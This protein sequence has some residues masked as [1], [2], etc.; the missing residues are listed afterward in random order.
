MTHVRSN[1]TSADASVRSSYS[2]RFPTTIVHGDPSSHAKLIRNPITKGWG[3]PVIFLLAIVLPHWT[4]RVWLST[5]VSMATT[6]PNLGLVSCDEHWSYHQ[7]TALKSTT[8]SLHPKFI[9]AN[10][11][12]NRID[13]QLA[14]YC[15]TNSIHGIFMW[16]TFNLR[17]F[18]RSSRLRRYTKT[19]R[20]HPWL[21]TTQWTACWTHNL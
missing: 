10:T 8:S 3:I 13:R 14:I 21:W 2:L 6:T 12:Q 19:G 7:L 20:S 9:A 11:F 17:T 16:P 18:S 15:H 1:V 4:R 5:C